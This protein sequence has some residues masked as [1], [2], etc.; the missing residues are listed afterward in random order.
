MI[1]EEIKLDELEKIFDESSK[2]IFNFLLE[3]TLIS[4]P[5]FLEGQNEHSIYL[6]KKQCEQ[7]VVQSLGLRPVG[8]GSYPIDGIKEEND[9]KIGF[10]VS[11]V[12][13]GLTPTG[14]NKNETGEK[15]LSQKF[16][17]TN[18]GD[19]EDTLDELFKNKKF[20]EILDS[21]KT[22][23]KNKWNNT[24]NEKSLD[25]IALI[26][27]VKHVEQKKIYILGLKIYPENINSCNIKP[28]KKKGDQKSVFIEN[29]INDDLGSVK[30]YKSKKR[31]ELRIRPKKWLENGSILVFDFNFKNKTKNLRNEFLKNK[32]SFLDN[33]M[34]NYSNF[35]KQYY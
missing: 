15:S 31:V 4:Y 24:I 11:T 34:K 17:D 30:I 9:S 25:Y 8:E 20:D 5:E 29:F 32:K 14:K 6:E 19:T 33:Q 7:W 3:R 21:W 12:N 10:D 22:I 18:F 28:S 23:L 35:L 26:N 16:A 2:S 1:L 13:W 27:I